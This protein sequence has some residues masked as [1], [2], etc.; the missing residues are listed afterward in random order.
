M[1]KVIENGDD[2]S[3]MTVSTDAGE[4]TTIKSIN[5]WESFGQFGTESCDFS[6]EKAN[7]PGDSMFYINQA[8][9]SFK[10]GKKSLLYRCFY[11]STYNATRTSAERYWEL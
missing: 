7:L 3:E 9:Q 1:G 10:D 8:Y 5:L 4:E 2:R 11:H 6:I